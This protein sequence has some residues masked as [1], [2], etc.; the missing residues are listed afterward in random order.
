MAGRIMLLLVTLLAA[1]L[2]GPA[3]RA[4]PNGGDASV[5]SVRVE[6]LHVDNAD[7]EAAL[8]ALR[9]TNTTKILVGL[10]Q[11][12]HRP[13]EKA[14]PISLS[15]SNAT[16]GEVLDGLCRQDPGY[17]YEVVEDVLVHVYPRNR[18][19]DPAGLLSIRIATFSVRGVMAPSAVIFRIGELAPELASYLRDMR[20]EY[21][22]RH[23]I[24]PG[25]SPGVTMH[26]NMEPYIR[27]ELRNVTVRE[28]LNAVV[29]YSRRLNEEAIPDA[30]RNKPQ[31]TRWMYEFVVDPRARTGLGGTPH[32]S[33]F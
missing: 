21:N 29:L 1:S 24:A 7:M 6:S 30:N 13:D 12:A 19:S 3:G 15:L 16:V 22:A 5:L 9:G 20:N 18:G 23:G 28:I 26:G 2:A 10:E 14:A 32:W 4:L 17:K 8:R 33:T 31:P 11:V 25:G 27:M